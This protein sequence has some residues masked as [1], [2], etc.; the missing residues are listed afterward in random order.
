MLKTF[1]FMDVIN[2]FHGF[3]RGIA[4]AT[5]TEGIPSLYFLPNLALT[6]IQ[7]AFY[8]RQDAIDHEVRIE[9]DKASGTYSESPALE[10]ERERG[11]NPNKEGL[12]GL[13]LNGPL[14]TYAGAGLGYAAGWFLTN[15]V[16]TL[17]KLGS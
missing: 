4:D 12:L 7:W 11:Y 17:S 6:S 1:P 15:A 9:A 8:R 3:S 13:V 16:K 2:L 14:F 5:N 10:E